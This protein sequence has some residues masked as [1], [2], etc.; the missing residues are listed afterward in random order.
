MLHPFPPLSSEKIRHKFS[1]FLYEKIFF[2]AVPT[3][4]DSQNCC[5]LRFLVAAVVVGVVYV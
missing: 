1:I 3:K 4:D 2:L 5:Y